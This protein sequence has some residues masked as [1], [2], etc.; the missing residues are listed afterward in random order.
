AAYQMVVEKGHRGIPIV[1]GE[2]LVGIVTVSDLLRI[3]R[4]KAA[5]TPLRDV[6]TQSVLVAH[7]DDNLFVALE[8]MTNHG[9]GRLP[10][11]SK[12]S[13]RLV[14]IVTRTD[15]IR[16]YERSMDMLSKSEPT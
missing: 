1:D 6:M 7:L 2:K 10:V 15:V 14:G 13:G 9:I 16:A 11:I 8:T 3:P 12:D 5:A 4:E